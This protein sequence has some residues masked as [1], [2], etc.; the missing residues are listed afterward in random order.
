MNKP[1]VSLG[2]DGLLT[3]INNFLLPRISLARF[4]RGDAGPMSYSASASTASLDWEGYKYLMS[5]LASTALK[6]QRRVRQSL[7]R[8][9]GQFAL[10][11]QWAVISNTEYEGKQITM[12][13]G[14]CVGVHAEQNLKKN[15][16]RLDQSITLGD[17]IVAHLFRQDNMNHT[18]KGP[19]LCNTVNASSSPITPGTSLASH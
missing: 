9:K 6:M 19:R 13:P 3:F 2:P 18:A 17:F 7:P 4:L 15:W 5:P 8:L 10:S 1:P 11:R 12:R 16:T 14:S